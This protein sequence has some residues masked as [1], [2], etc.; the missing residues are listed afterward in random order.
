MLYTHIDNMV[1]D[2][3]LTKIEIDNL[4]I[5]NFVYHIVNMQ[6]SWQCGIL[7]IWADT[8]SCNGH[9]KLSFKK[10]L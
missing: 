8:A 5:D 4:E 6:K 9:G 2:N 10:N 3:I 7:T 1:F